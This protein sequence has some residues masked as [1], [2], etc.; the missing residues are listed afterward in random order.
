V[1]TLFLGYILF[2]RVAFPP[3]AESWS[4]VTSLAVHSRLSTFLPR[5]LN[6]FL[7]YRVRSSNCERNFCWFPL[8]WEI[9]CSFVDRDALW[10]FGELRIYFAQALWK[11]RHIISGNNIH[12]SL[13]FRTF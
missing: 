7:D 11:R 9:D 2:G 5:E 3:S 10:V 8:L 12:D 1:A 4:T 6:H 13:T